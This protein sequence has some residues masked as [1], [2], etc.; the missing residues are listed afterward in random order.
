[1]R[2]AL[3]FIALVAFVTP[4]CALFL[5]PGQCLSESDCLGGDLCIEGQCIECVDDT[6]C[7]DNHVCD[8][9]ECIRDRGGVGEGEG[10]GEGGEGEGE[11]EGSVRRGEEAGCA[12]SGLRGWEC[13]VLG[14]A[15][16]VCVSYKEEVCG[17]VEGVEEGEEGGGSECLMGWS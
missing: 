7:G 12:E 3:V 10:E 4:S 6:D 15:G 11:G 16:G 9:G 17:H 14:S 5:A 13:G 8:D 1:M 2:F